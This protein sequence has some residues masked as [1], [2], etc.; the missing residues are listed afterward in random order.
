MRVLRAGLTACCLASALLSGCTS[1]TNSSDAPAT[2]S[3]SP[4]PSLSEESREKELGDQA[5]AALDAAG[6]DSRFVEAGLERVREG[7]HTR[8]DLKQ[9]KPYQLVVACAGKGAVNV[10]IDGDPPRVVD[11]DGVSNRQRITGTSGPLKID[12][13]G[14]KGS[15]GMVAWRITS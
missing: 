6:N 14:A 7:I 4:T 1:E 10:T 15:S 8:P 9:G 3:A 2:E 13:N 12:V 11:C 5:T